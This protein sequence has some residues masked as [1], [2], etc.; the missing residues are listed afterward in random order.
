MSH[1]QGTA[2]AIEGLFPYDKNFAVHI[3]SE[4]YPGKAN[5]VLNKEDGM[6][7]VRYRVGSKEKPILEQI[8]AIRFSI[9]AIVQFVFTLDSPTPAQ[10]AE[11]YIAGKY[12]FSFVP[13]GNRVAAFN[14][15]VT[16]PHKPGSSGEEDEWTAKGGASDDDETSASC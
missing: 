10:I 7:I 6:P 15:S 12:T 16:D 8:V 1:P 14:G 5:L 2:P 4:N 9:D 13:P 3:L 11:G